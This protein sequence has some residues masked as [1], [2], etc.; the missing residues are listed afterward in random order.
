MPIR[1]SSHSHVVSV[2]VWDCRVVLVVDEV[3]EM[4]DGQSLRS[5]GSQISATAGTSTYQARVFLQQC[6][7]KVCSFELEIAARISKPQDRT[8]AF[9]PI[10]AGRRAWCG[11]L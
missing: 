1:G 5:M 4:S 11:R 10:E 2:L 6:T 7:R 3:E 9:A 8:C